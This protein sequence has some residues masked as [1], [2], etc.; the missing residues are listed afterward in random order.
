MK[1]CDRYGVLDDNK[2][3]FAYATQKFYAMMDSLCLC[4][5]AWGLGVAVC[6]ARKIW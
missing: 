3:R 4:Q 6:T 5:F 2:A 1:K